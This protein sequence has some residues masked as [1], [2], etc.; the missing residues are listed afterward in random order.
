MYF[1]ETQVT[2][3]VNNPPLCS[4]SLFKL[5][6][7]AVFVE[8]GEWQLD[9]PGSKPE[10]CILI[11]EPSAPEHQSPHLSCPRSPSLSGPHL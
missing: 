8:E 10:P 6:C 2:Y 5:C 3:Q 7:E 9:T 4:P 1:Y 11:C